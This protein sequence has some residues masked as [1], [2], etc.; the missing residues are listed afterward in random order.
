MLRRGRRTKNKN[1]RRGIGFSRCR[2][3]NRPRNR[4][5]VL[6][7]NPFDY[8]Y[9]NRCAGAPLTTRKP[10]IGHWGR[11]TPP[12]PS[13]PRRRAS[14]KLVCGVGARR[15]DSPVKPENDG[16]FSR[17]HARIFHRHARAGGRPGSW[18]SPSK[19]CVWIPGQAGN[20]G[21]WKVFLV[22]VVVFVVVIVF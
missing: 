22:V 20:D 5:L 10:V 21:A 2:R 4:L 18:S 7:S 16:L 15:L 8:D 3:R 9:D 1:R 6:T 11:Q 19:L 17:R 14:R 12:M 13:C